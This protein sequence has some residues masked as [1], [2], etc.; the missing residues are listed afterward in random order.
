MGVIKM[1]ISDLSTRQKQIFQMLLNTDDYLPCKQ[2]ATRLNISIRTVKSDVS[3]LK[4][5]IHHFGCRFESV[6]SKGY[7]IVYDSIKNISGDYLTNHYFYSDN[8]YL[9]DDY[10]QVKLFLDIINSESTIAIKDLTEKYYISRTTLY[11]DLQEISKDF[12][13]YN[14]ELVYQPYKGVY[15]E[16][17]EVSI[18]FAIQHKL[19]FNMSL[20]ED[21]ISLYFDQTKFT[22]D[23][24]L[25]FIN[26]FSI[27]KISDFEL[28]NV[29]YHLM[30]L[31]M[32]CK[33]G[34]YVSFDDLEYETFVN[35]FEIQKIYEYFYQY[36]SES[37]T[38]PRTEI[39]YFFLLIK[40]GNL[41]FCNQFALDLTVQS[42]NELSRQL[43][44]DFNDSIRIADLS[45]YL[46]S[47]FIRHLN[48]FTQNVVLL[49]DIKDKHALSFDIAYQ[50]VS[51]I[52]KSQGIKIKSSEIA[53]LSYYF[54]NIREELRKYYNP[55][56][57]LLV[58]FRGTTMCRFL[59][60]ELQTEFN[61]YQFESCELY[62]VKQKAEEENY[63]FIISDVGLYLDTD[64][65][66]IVINHFMNSDDYK[67]VRKHLRIVLSELLDDYLLNMK[68]TSLSNKED[69]LRYISTTEDE[70]MA[71]LKRD[72][73]FTYQM[74]QAAVI[75]LYNQK[76]KTRIYYSKKG[77]LWNGMIIHYI[78]VLNITENNQLLNYS[79][80]IRT[81]LDKIAN[82]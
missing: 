34:K 28:F 65:P 9:E 60:N 39:I 78:F 57:I 73:R 37:L 31:L 69:F 68:R 74:D 5:A 42:L 80:V 18:R 8:K 6:P 66:I 7:R 13:N 19:L 43:K 16:G 47:L 20:L 30:S 64:I 55:I 12:K 70:Y 44:I 67:I 52:E 45:K 33:I 46:Y 77:I 81:F 21:E 24:L 50:F 58:S 23:N 32:R 29:Y 10:R 38:I 25:D 11:K 41:G 15:I 71:L 82:K 56:K 26:S 4:G 48:H 59:L 27:N 17:T 72:E 75:F 22:K 62:E 49:D 40:G 3:I 61:F 63:S 1:N 2:I 53:Y 76:V 79:K 54:L 51:I 36:K 14:V 35:E